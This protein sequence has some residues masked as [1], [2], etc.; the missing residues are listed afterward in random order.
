M[1]SAATSL[2]PSYLVRKPKTVPSQ[3]CYSTVLYYHSHAT[4]LYCTIIDMLQYC[5]VLS[6]PCYSTVLYFHS[7]ATVL[8]YH[9]W[10]YSWPPSLRS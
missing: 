3:P 10:S 4:V 8:Y 1:S 7:H 5:T 6:Q 9:S 2:S